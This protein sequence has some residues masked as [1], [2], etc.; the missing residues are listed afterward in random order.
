MAKPILKW[1]GGKGQLISSLD[2]RIP[3]EFR[4]GQITTY[5]EPFIGGG[6]LLFYVLSKY[7]VENAYISDVN[8]ELILFYCVVQRH[9][10]QLLDE[11]ELLSN[12][13]YAFD[14]QDDRK[15][16]FYQVRQAFNESN[17]YDYIHIN[18][19]NH[20]FVD[21]ENIQNACIRAAQFFF[22]N[23]TCFNGLF[24]VNKSGLFNV[25]FGNYKNPVIF[26]AERLVVCSEQLKIVQIA[27][28]SYEQIP[29]EFLQHSFIYFDPPYR[30]LSGSSSFTAY[31]KSGFNDENQA[32]LAE[33]FA[34][35]G[36]NE[37]IYL[38]LSNS[39]PKNVDVDDN[40]FDE[41]YQGFNIER[42]LA[43]RMIN[44]NGAGRGK[45]NEILVRN[46]P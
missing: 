12:H 28:S 5:A 38:M 39:D 35:I 30:P 22:L 19:L 26:D 34:S 32:A 46:Y 18:E 42:V 31:S 8:P 16:F 24:R 37:N 9:P 20:N 33:Y 40:F 14:E 13:Y 4:N 17:V 10:N 43:S 29:D 1:A 7:Q 11:L 41:L 27:L 45:I 36:N 21:I 2:D 6:A 44:A 23:R 15:D 3:K 25:P